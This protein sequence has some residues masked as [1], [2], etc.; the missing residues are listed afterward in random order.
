[1]LV[2]RET[3]LTTYVTVKQCPLD[4]KRLVEPAGLA[5]YFKIQNIVL[6]CKSI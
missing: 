1:M 5:Q 2:V 6:P 3:W 4:G